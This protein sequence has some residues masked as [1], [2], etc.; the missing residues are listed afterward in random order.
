MYEDKSLCVTQTVT[1]L[2]VYVLVSFIHED[3]IYIYIFA[4][5]EVCWEIIRLQRNERI[6]IMKSHHFD[7]EVFFIYDFSLKKVRRSAIVLFCLN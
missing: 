5:E 7:D 1:Y 3:N 6:V 2:Y 4:N